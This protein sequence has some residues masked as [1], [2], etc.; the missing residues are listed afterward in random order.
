VQYDVN[1]NIL[2]IHDS[3]NIASKLLNISASSIS[4]CCSGRIKTSAGFKW[5]L[6]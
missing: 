2:E 6:A 3:I 1:N 4:D 5:E